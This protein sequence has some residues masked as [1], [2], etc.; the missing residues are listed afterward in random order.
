MGYMEVIDVEEMLR[1]AGIEGRVVFYG[2]EDIT[3]RNAF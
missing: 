3:A 2:L 1:D